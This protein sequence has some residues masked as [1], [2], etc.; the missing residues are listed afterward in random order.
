MTP[1]TAK[2]VL[3]NA[4][5]AAALAAC[6]PEGRGGEL[7]ALAQPIMSGTVDGPNG[8]PSVVAIAIGSR[9]LCSGTLISPRA[10]LTAAHCLDL[11]AKPAEYRVG[12]GTDVASAVW[13]PV[14]VLTKHPQWDSKNLVNDIAVVG[15]AAPAP[16]GSVT[17]PPLPARLGVTAADVG[18]LIVFSGFGEDES[19]AAGIRLRV[20]SRVGLACEGPEACL[21]EQVPVAPRTIAYDEKIGGA[22]Y[23]DSGGPAFVFRTENGVALEYVAGVTSYGGRGCTTAGV[24]TKVDAFGDFLAPYLPLPPAPSTDTGC[25]SAGGAT[26][27]ALGILLALR[28]MRRGRASRT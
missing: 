4:V 10:V 27:A 28:C 12:F 17:R 23:G 3:L 15:L 24:S 9:G 8:H 26:P 19:G 1:A 18:S 22:C 11:S 2:A 6:G 14:A 21:Y 13:V 20:N 7:G 16:V 5:L 25:A